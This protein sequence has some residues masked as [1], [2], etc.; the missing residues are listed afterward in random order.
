MNRG[1][2]HRSMMSDKNNT[3]FF[4]TVDGTTETYHIMFDYGVRRIDINKNTRVVL[5]FVH[6]GFE[7]IFSRKGNDLIIGDDMYFCAPELLGV[8]YGKEV[9]TISCDGEGNYSAEIKKYTWMGSKRG[10]S[11]TP[12]TV[13]MQVM[14]QDEL[15]EFAES[16]GLTLNEGENTLYTTWP[17]LPN[18]NIT[19]HMNDCG[20]YAPANGKLILKNYFKYKNNDI[21][22][23]NQLLSDIIKGVEN[24]DVTKRVF[25]NKQHIIYDSF[26][27]ENIKGKDY[28][29]VIFSRQGD[30]TITGGKGNDR[31]YLGEG[32][33]TVVI[34]EGDERDIIYKTTNGGTTRISLDTNDI[35]YTKSGNHL[36]I[37][38]NYGFQTE[39]TILNNFFKNPDIYNQLVI[40]NGDTI[41]SNNLLQDLITGNQ[42]ISFDNNIHNIKGSD[43]SDEFYTTWQDE[44]FSTGKGNDVIHFNLHNNFN[45]RYNF[46]YNSFGEDTVNITQNSNITLDFNT[47]DDEN[48][49]FAYRKNGSDAVITATREVKITLVRIWD[50]LYSIQNGANNEYKVTITNYDFIDGSY[51]E[52][53]EISQEVWTE[54]TFANFRQENGLEAQ[55]NNN[56]LAPDNYVIDP[57]IWHPIMQDIVLNVFIGSVTLKDYFKYNNSNIY[58]GN[59]S[60]QDILEN[61][62]NISTINESNSAKATKIFD[63]FLDDT[64]TGSR[65]SDSITSSFGDD[66]ITS[67]KGNDTIFLGEGNKTVNIS[68]V[69]GLDIINISQNNTSTDIVFDDDVLEVS[70]KKSSNNLIISRKYADKTEKTI[71]KNFYRYNLENN[72]S[73]TVGDEVIWD[74][75]TDSVNING[76][77]FEAIPDYQLDQYSLN[78]INQSIC[79][80]Q[81]TDNY[82]DTYSFADVMDYDQLPV[83]VAQN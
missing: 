38:R 36:V 80:W 67:G 12:T 46:F 29:E 40:T 68:K 76:T 74:S 62:E 60:L 44:T 61:I 10:Y 49:K 23:G 58:I 34:S 1:I 37:N 15:T 64:I 2:I 16:F 63:T 81:S 35:N 17:V 71:I 75:S 69:D 65:F 25:I 41:I 53:G 73:I 57:I 30:D 26:L 28:S 20:Y 8:G 50:R 42:K 51:Q 6:G 13:E 83:L 19:Y 45:N 79:S 33:K 66:N 70:L 72:I 24:F 78:E 32:N 14:T 48:I 27:S 77:V 22:V 31:I 43:L 5:D 18:P 9:W 21:Y 47:N 7:N 39:Q 55:A 82:S 4:K 59:T 3:N 52:N 11:D 54:D 56:L